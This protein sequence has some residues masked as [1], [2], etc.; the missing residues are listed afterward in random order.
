MNSA[1]L[2]QSAGLAEQRP[3][4]Y[5]RLF[6]VLDLS[7]SAQS[8]RVYFNLGML[9]MDDG[10][11]A[12]AELWFK[13]AVSIKPNFRSALFNLALLLNEQ[14]RPLEAL[15]FLISLHTFYPDHVKGLIL[16]GDIYTNHVK[17]LKAA[18]RCYRLITEVDPGHVQGHHNLCVV[19]VEQGH[20]ERARDCLLKVM[21]MAPSEKY[22]KKHL[23][24]VDNRIRA[25]ATVT[26]ASTETTRTALPT[27]D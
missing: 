20:L 13:K 17:D 3:L 18:E 14:K 7:P 12:N 15:P 4:A 1:I 27:V 11:S 26:T 9:A 6:R 10:N 21:E 23:Q 19:L 8:D 22:V 2:M 5:Q 25:A 24:I 16:M